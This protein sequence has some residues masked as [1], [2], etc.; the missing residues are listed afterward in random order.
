M[1]YV[2]ETRC[3]YVGGDFSS[4][5]HSS[6]QGSSISDP[7]GSNLRSLCRVRADDSIQGDTLQGA[8]NQGESNDIDLSGRMVWDSLGLEEIG[9]QTELASS[10][11]MLHPVRV[12]V[13]A[14]STA[15]D[16]S[17]TC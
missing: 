1:A 16:T 9:S 10:S 11:T 5:T 8:S 4:K 15:S 12:I 7:H 13:D 17:G 14:S 3:L 2:P 6:A